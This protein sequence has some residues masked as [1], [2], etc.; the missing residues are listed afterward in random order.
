YLEAMTAR[1]L[2]A[3]IRLSGI[4]QAPDP[5]RAVEE[6]QAIYVGGGNTFRLLNEM[7]RANLLNVIRERVRD[8]MPYMGVSAGSNVACPTI[9]TTNDMPIV[10]PPTFDALDLVPF[11]INA[12]YYWGRTFVQRGE[13]MTEHFGETRDER[14]AEFHEEN[15]TPVIG[16]WEGGFLRVEDSS[17]QLLGE[18]A[19]LF[20][21]GRDPMDI[22]PGQPVWPPVEPVP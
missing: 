17:V 7:Y 22:L 15:D 4:H 14:L 8:G 16:L 3:G 19:R 21:R 13:T 2:D 10:R 6:A 5:V 1:G 9:Q 18:A 12:H 20:R 11:Q